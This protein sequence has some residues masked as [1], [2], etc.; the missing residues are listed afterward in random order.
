[1]NPL[2]I[3]AARQRSKDSGFNPAA[4]RYAGTVVIGYI[5][6]GGAEYGYL[7]SYNVGSIT[8]DALD[9]R[10]IKRASWKDKQFHAPATR[11]L[12]LTL[13]GNQR[14]NITKLALV[15]DGQLVVELTT[16]SREGSYGGPDY[17]L[18]YLTGDTEMPISGTVQLYIE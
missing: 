3:A 13:S 7:K 4:Y 5:S 6:A 1:M 16:P 11:E 9:T 12:F 15:K 8:P 10:T 18:V 2:L 14:P 17:T